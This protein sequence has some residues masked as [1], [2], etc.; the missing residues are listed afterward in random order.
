MTATGSA[1]NSTED[2]AA[3]VVGVDVADLRDRL[4][5]AQPAM[6]ELLER[7][8]VT[9][10]PTAR[11]AAVRQVQ[12]LL[13]A[14]LRSAGLRVRRVPGRESAGVLVATPSNRR[15]GRPFQMLVGHCDTVWPLGTLQ[16]MPLRREGDRLHGPGVFDMKAG[17]VQMLFALRTLKTM[18]LTPPA[19]CVV[20]IDSD[21]E[22]GSRDA[23]RTIR[24][25]ARRAAR[26]YV[27]EPA[28]GPAG[29]LKTSRKGVGGF[30]IQVTG[31][32]AHAGIAPQEGVSAI[33]EMS[34]QIQHLFAMNDA[35]RGITVNVG[36]IEGGV[37]ANVV[38]AEVRASIDVRVPTL[39][40]AAAVET[41][42]RGLTPSDPRTSIRV[43]G[44][45]EHP[46][47]ERTARNVA[48]WNAAR[49]LGTAL[50]LELQEA[51]VGGAS[52]GNTISQYTATLDGL[53]AVGDGAHAAHEYVDV[54][55]LVDR[56]CLLVLLLM[57]PMLEMRT[58]S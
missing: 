17:L 15:R 32:A 3:L 35:T 12:S 21:E 22:Q 9:E 14:E 44:G 49:E 2:S 27:L 29:R 16:A 11:P 4:Q 26:A 40:D 24:R 57:R 10:S 39:E 37:G 25:L 43:E 31:K 45:F 50:G 58:D 6:V 7:L 1:E 38:A 55:R 23:A 46:P 8:V 19:D 56:T 42:I 33:L 47:L 30:Q 13:E 18:G 53:G 51:A 36:Q 20:V 52:D 41:A 54:T 48:L 28:F 5:R 34:L